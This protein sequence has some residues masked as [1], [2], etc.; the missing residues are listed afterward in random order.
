MEGGRR[1]GGGGWGW[2]VGWGWGGSGGMESRANDSEVAHPIKQFRQSSRSL[3]I[4]YLLPA[5]FRRSSVQ[6]I[7]G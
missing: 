4:K 1:G 7:S 2:G 6:N 5:L 3:Y